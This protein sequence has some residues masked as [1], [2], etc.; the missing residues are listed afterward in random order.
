MMA[1]A[2]RPPT[3]APGHQPPLCPRQ[4]IWSVLVGTAASSAAAFDIMGAAATGVAAPSAI[5]PAKPRPIACLVTN[6]RIGSLL[7]KRHTGRILLLP[8]APG[9]ARLL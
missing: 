5:A 9:E 1:P 3:T 2:A 7:V 4:R 6:L 8:G